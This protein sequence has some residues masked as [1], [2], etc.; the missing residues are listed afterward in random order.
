VFKVSSFL[1]LK[2]LKINVRALFHTESKSSKSKR[3]H[4]VKIF[5]GK[6]VSIRILLGGMIFVTKRS[7]TRV[8]TLGKAD[9]FTSSLVFDNSRKH[10]AVRIKLKD[11]ENRKLLAFF[12]SNVRSLRILTEVHS[13]VITVLNG[14]EVRSGATGFKQG[15]FILRGAR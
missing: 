5:H 14:I 2:G 9:S 12:F 13:T 11:F 6:S 15:K 4:F 10:F 7:D 8:G 3:S 1:I